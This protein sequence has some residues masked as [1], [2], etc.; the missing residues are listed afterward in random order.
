[1][2]TLCIIVCAGIAALCAACGTTPAAPQQPGP[3]PVATA[4]MTPAQPRDQAIASEVPAATPPAQ[5]QAPAHRSWYEADPDSYSIV[6]AGRGTSLHKP[7]YALPYT[8]SPAYEGR[9]TETMFQ[10]SLKQR[11]FGIPLY[12]AY[13]QKSFW[14][15]YNTHESA[16]FKETDYNPELF[17]RYIPQDRER[18][19]HLGADLGFEHESNG[20]GLP[21][22]RSWNRFYFAAF[23]AEGE[24][25]IYWKWWYRLPENDSLPATDPQRDDNPH[26]GY[27]Y[28]YSE[29]N[30]EQQLFGKQLAHFMVRYNP[31][32]GKG[33]VQLQYTAPNNAAD[34]DFFWMLYLWQGYGESLIDYNRSIFRIGVG[35]ALAR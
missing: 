4:G 28:G 33:A 21:D 31:I 32:T 23:Q 20:Q 16:P 1:M 22:S 27:Y 10:I 17:Y 6:S 7:M 35:I 19:H 13:T 30:Y 26:I 18:W 8:W 11:L 34:P 14:Q 12:A 24:H 2:R 9:D 5:A 15:A 25:L 3:A 29:L